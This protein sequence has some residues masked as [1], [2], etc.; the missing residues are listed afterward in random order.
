[1]KIS[2][3]YDDTLS[4]KRGMELAK[5]LIDDGNSL[6]IISA[7]NDKEGMLKRADE[8]GIP[9]SRVYATGSNKSKVEKILELEIE[10]HYDNNSDVIKDLGSKGEKFFTTDE[11]FDEIDDLLNHPKLSDDY[12]F[13]KIHNLLFK[14]IYG[15]TRT[16]NKSIKSSNVWKFKY[17]TETGDLVVKFQDGS[18]YTYFKVPLDDKIF[19]IRFDG[20]RSPHYINYK[21]HVFAWFV[22]DGVV[23]KDSKY[24]PQGI[25]FLTELI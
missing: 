4:T 7:R 10:R 24:Q 15:N 5:K 21:N 6:Y 13:D 18:V 11:I 17:N 20:A 14:T 16:R 23:Y 22:F 3:D 9:H 1:M 2:F 25:Q 12:K 19:S 8:L